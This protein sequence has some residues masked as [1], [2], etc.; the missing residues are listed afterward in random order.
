MSD[1]FEEYRKELAEQNLSTFDDLVELLKP[2]VRDATKMILK[3]VE[4]KDEYTQLYPHFGGDPYFEEGEKWPGMEYGSP[5]TFICQVFNEKGNNLPEDIELVQFFYDYEDSP[6]NSSQNGWY[7]KIYTD[8]LVHD[9][10]YIP[11]PEGIRKTKY[12]RIEYAP[13]KSLPTWEELKYRNPLA[14]KLS[15]VLNEERP[16]EN[17]GIAAKKLLGKAE[18]CSQVGGYAQWLQSAQIPIREDLKEFQFLM[19]IDSEDDAELMWRDMGLVY[20]FWDE[21]TEETR[22]ILQS[23]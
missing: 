7:I 1:R 5:A 9:M 19:Q 20:L 8:L 16:W 11:T 17:Y 23:M 22:F 10:E 4:P 13:V 12:C 14:F 3:K 2:T 18:I 15:C 21:E 6:S